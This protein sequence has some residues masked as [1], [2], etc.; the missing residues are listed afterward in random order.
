MSEIGIIGQMYEDRRTKKKGK[1]LERD[2]KYKT[3]LMETPDGK[4]FN[5]S[6][7]SFKS[8]WRSCEE[9]VIIEEPVIEE[10]EE[11]P[12]EKPKKKYKEQQVK[13]GYEDATLR[14]LDYAKSFND[15]SVI[16]KA[17]PAK[18]RLTIKADNRRMFILTYLTRSDS[19]SV[20]V[21]ENF[22]LV[23]KDNKYVVNGKYNE[24]WLG[25]KYSFDLSEDKLDEFLEDARSYIIDYMCGKIKEEEE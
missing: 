4:S 18:R 6:F 8:N 9:E 21:T 16:L 17:A 12:E 1:L 10:P 14:L 15:S 23:L 22:F 19:F 2:E 20:C 5:V 3:L 11:V 13:P 24:K 25:M 7:G